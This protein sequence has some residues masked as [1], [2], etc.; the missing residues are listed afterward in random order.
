M[1]PKFISTEQPDTP[2]WGYNMMLQRVDGSGFSDGHSNYQAVK[3]LTTIYLE[4]KKVE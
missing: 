4:C 2:H 3:I 1:R